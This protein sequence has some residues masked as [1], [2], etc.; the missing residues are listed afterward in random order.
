[1]SYFIGARYIGLG[2]TRTI[3]T[4]L[5]ELS[6]VEHTKYVLQFVESI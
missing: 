5:G 6:R 3:A 1:M 4:L 2:S